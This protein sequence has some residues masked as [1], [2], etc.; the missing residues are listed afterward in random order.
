M[1]FWQNWVIDRSFR[2]LQELRK[3]YKF[4]LIGGWAVYFLTKLLKS[5]DIDII[6]DF[7]ELERMKVE[8]RIEKT[9]FLKKYSCEIE[10]IS[11]DIYVPYYSE[12]AIPPEEIEKN[13]IFVEGFRIP[14]PEILLILKQQAEMERKNTIKGQKDRVDILGLLLAERIDFE[15]YKKFLRKFRLKGYEK[16]LREIIMNSS[17]EF[18]YLGVKNPREIKKLKKKLISKMC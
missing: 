15:K 11:I 7:V 2:V 16:R 17:K 5:K 14:S 6:V 12:L 18:E 10:G 13:T 3:K 9:E 1:E 8:M 4:I